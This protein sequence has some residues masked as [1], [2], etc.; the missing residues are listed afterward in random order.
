MHITRCKL[1]NAYYLLQTSQHI[2]PVANYHI[3][4]TYVI[5]IPLSLVY[6]V[7]SSSLTISSSPR[8]GLY[9]E[10]N[11]EWFHKVSEV[12]R[13]FLSRH[14]SV[15]NISKRSIPPFIVGTL[16]ANHLTTVIDGVS[17]SKFKIIN[18]L[19]A[20]RLV[21]VKKMSLYKVQGLII[22]GL[23]PSDTTWTELSFYGR[24]ALLTT[25]QLM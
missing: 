20:H 22:M 10:T 13:S 15:V 16:L 19:I 5:C 6:K 14:I 4:F 9:P 24:K 11:T 17:V 23:I 25:R 12:I 18:H 2:L 8:L 3:C 21:P 7:T 1:P